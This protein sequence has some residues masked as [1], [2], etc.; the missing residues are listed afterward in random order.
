MSPMKKIKKEPR[1]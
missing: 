1:V